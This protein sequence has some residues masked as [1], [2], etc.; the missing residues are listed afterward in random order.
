MGFLLRTF[1]CVA[2]LPTAV[3]KCCNLRLSYIPMLIGNLNTRK[4][5]GRDR[6][7][8]RVYRQL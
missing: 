5:I 3:Q 8:C 2:A 7:N 6:R 1:I 4:S